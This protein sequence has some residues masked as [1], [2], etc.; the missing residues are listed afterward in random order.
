MQFTPL[1]VLILLGA[2]QGF[3]LAVLLLRRQHGHSAEGW[4]VALMIAYGLGVSGIALG[5]SNAYTVWPHLV[6][7]TTALPLLYGPLHY[8]YVRDLLADRAAPR[9]RDGWHILPFIG[10]TLYLVPFYLESAA[11]KRAFFEAMLVGEGPAVLDIM[12]V[13]KGLH[14][15]LYLGA[16]LYLLRR[17]DR[18]GRLRTLHRTWLWRLTLLTTG[19]WLL[20]AAL[21]SLDGLGVTSLNGV[22]VVMG[23]AMA[24]AIYAIGYLG[25]RQPNVF[26]DVPAR[27]TTTKYAHSGLDPDEAEDHAQ[28]LRQALAERQLYRQ[29]GL[30]LPELARAVDVSP[31]HLSQVINDHLGQNF[32]DLVNAYRVEA[33]QRVLGDPDRAH[34]TMLAVADEVGFG[35]R[36]AFNTAFKKHTG[37]TPSQYKKR[38]LRSEKMS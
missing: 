27:K 20:N 9:L 16:A 28:R 12:A 19:L 30:A 7:T 21:L 24:G 4:L 6:G 5:L 36:S 38:A 10:Y 15:L 26:A 1:S 35:S 31:H 23:L 37:M 14:G 25:L 2:A 17:Q 3:F 32:F 29:S 8:L 34:W 18:A 11:Y 22:D 33:A 13:I